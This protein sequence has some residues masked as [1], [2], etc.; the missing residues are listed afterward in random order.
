MGTAANS[1][2]TVSAAN[3]NRLPH[4]MCAA[5]FATCI[6]TPII[7]AG[8]PFVNRM[9]LPD[10]TRVLF[11]SSAPPRPLP[12]LKGTRDA[13]TARRARHRFRLDVIAANSA[14]P[15]SCA[16]CAAQEQPD[17]ARERGLVLRA[18]PNARRGISVRRIAAVRFGGACAARTV[19]GLSGKRGK[20]H[21][22]SAA[23][24][25]RRP[26]CRAEKTS[27]QGKP[28]PAGAR[29]SGMVDCISRRGA[30][31]RPDARRRPLRTP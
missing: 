17:F 7:H 24:A 21:A 3:R 16:V 2:A 29:N 9:R 8:A 12:A 31:K 19:C 10:G 6:V 1:A 11:R 20:V 15:A 13:G 4:F 18:Q 30:C 5:S 26:P 25:R 28:L 27:G 23:H 14:M 22:D